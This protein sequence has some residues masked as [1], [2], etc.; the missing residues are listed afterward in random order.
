MHQRTTKPWEKTSTHQKATVGA[1]FTGAGQENGA[2]GSIRETARRE[3][4]VV[5]VKVFRLWV[6]KRQRE[7]E[8]GINLVHEKGCGNWRDDYWSG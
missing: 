6:E 2:D 7:T 3:K 8:K 1:W 5:L 4:E